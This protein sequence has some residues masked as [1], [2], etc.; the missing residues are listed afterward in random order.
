MTLFYIVMGGWL[1]AGLLCL[2]CMAGAMWGGK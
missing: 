1:A 2:V